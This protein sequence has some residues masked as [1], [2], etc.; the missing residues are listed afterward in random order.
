MGW[1]AGSIPFLSVIFLTIAL[2]YSLECAGQLPEALLDGGPGAGDVEALE[3]GAFAAEDVAAV[4]PKP[5]IVLD[6]F[7]EGVVAEA[8]GAEVEPEQIGALRLD[9]A[10]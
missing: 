6:A 9:E 2:S 7:I 1:S 10:D 4:E 5:G 3:A 8:V